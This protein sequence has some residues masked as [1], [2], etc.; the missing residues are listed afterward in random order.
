MCKTT[1]FSTYV[2][3]KVG[4]R[5]RK[6]TTGSRTCAKYQVCSFRPYIGGQKQSDSDL[7]RP[8]R[9]CVDCVPSPTTAQGCGHP[10]ISACAAYGGQMG[11]FPRGVP[12]CGGY[13]LCGMEQWVC[14]VPP[15]LTAS[16]EKKD[17]SHI[18][19]RAAEQ[20]NRS[21][22]MLGVE[23]HRMIGVV[24]NHRMIGLEETLR[25]IKLQPCAVGWL[26][27][28]RSGCPE[29]HPLWLWGPPRMGHPCLSGQQCQSL[30]PLCAKNF[31]LSSNLTFPSFSLKPLLLFLSLSDYVKSQS[32]SCLKALFKY[33][34][35]AM[36]SSWSLL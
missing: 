20:L 4:G 30:I 33:G 17:C 7:S 28:S 11:S 34:N 21:R 31:L 24:K 10:F 14:V 13:P 9:P 5:G 29:P 15:P 12:C 3:V 18:Q 26:P 32:L 36:R 27:P 35:A 16:W 22:I 19:R 2:M 25:I 6:T 1:A 8:S 23:N